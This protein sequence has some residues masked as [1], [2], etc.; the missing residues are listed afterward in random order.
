MALPQDPNI[1]LNGSLEDCSDAELKG[2]RGYTLHCLL[3]G[4]PVDLSSSARL[5][6]D[7]QQGSTSRAAS[8]RSK[9]VQ[10]KDFSQRGIHD[11]GS[12]LNM[13][14][15]S[16]QR[17]QYQLYVGAHRLQEKKGFGVRA[18]EFIP[19][20]ALHVGRTAILYCLDPA[21]IVR[22][23]SLYTQRLLFVGLRDYSKASTRHLGVHDHL[24][25]VLTQS[26]AC[27]LTANLAEQRYGTPPN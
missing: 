26:Y 20:G 13:L 12:L 21:F 22:T 11:R 3:D 17:C 5:V 16:G 14:A 10:T 4:S 18:L 15:T 23:W 25:R 27:V 19:A 9:R 2:L 24:C 1:Y 8:S 6:S 7:C